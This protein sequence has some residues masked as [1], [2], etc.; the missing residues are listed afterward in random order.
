MQFLKRGALLKTKG[1]LEG[2]NAVG[3]IEDDENF[4]FGSEPVTIPPDS[5]CMFVEDQQFM[6]SDK[7][8]PMSAWIRCNMIA[9]DQIIWFTLT[10]VPK[11][12]WDF[13]TFRGKQRMIMAAIEEK[14]DVLVVPPIV[15]DMVPTEQPTG[16]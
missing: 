1:I 7:Q 4:E 2:S 12:I 14:F 8:T 3:I 5:I 16:A 6:A 9:N 13:E 15:A 10:T 11:R